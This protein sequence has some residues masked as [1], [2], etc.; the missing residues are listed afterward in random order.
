MK[1]V[2]GCYC[3]TVRYE[4]SGDPQ[5]SLQC[6]CRECQ[7]ISGGNPTL[8]MIFPL[9]S[10]QLAS[11]EMNP[12]PRTSNNRVTVP[13]CIRTTPSDPLVDVQ[14]FVPI[15]GPNNGH[16][17]CSAGTKPEKWCDPSTPVMIDRRRTRQNASRGQIKSFFITVNRPRRRCNALCRIRTHDPLIKSQLL[18][19]LS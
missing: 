19:Q 18:C 3:G 12:K 11:G 2:G 4:I 17:D 16:V 7:Y 8:L 15:L 6:H 10:F 14:Q 5:A 9:E 1:I 13:V